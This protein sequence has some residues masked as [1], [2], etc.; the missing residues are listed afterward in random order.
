MKAQ[1][2]SDDEPTRP[3]N[4]SPKQW[5]K[6]KGVAQEM[7][8]EP[9]PAEKTLWQHLRNRQLRGERFR[10]QHTIG[11][12][13]VDFVCLN[14]RL[15]IEVDGEI[16]RQQIDYDEQRQHWLE[17]NEFRVLRFTNEQIIQSIDAVVDAI[18]AALG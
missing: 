4:S 10:R 16:H 12:F 3:Y 17:A 6:L 9:T 13:V 7:R 15:I 11:P 5:R 8:R 1:A 2:M 14:K 18:M